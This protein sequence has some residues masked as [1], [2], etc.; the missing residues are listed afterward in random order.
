MGTSGSDVPSSR[1]SAFTKQEE[2]APTVEFMSIK[3]TNKGLKLGAKKG[4][5]SPPKKKIGN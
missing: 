1:T 3:L 5:D 4:S 2:Q